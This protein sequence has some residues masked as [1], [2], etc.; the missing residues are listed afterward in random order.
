MSHL[1]RSL[2]SQ[3]VPNGDNNLSGLL[4]ASSNLLSNRS[5]SRNSDIVSLVSNGSQGPPILKE[6]H[7]A[8]LAAQ[9]PQRSSDVHDV[10]LEDV[11]TESYQSPGTSFPIQN[12]SPAYAQA[13]K[14]SAGRSKLINFDLNDVYDGSDDG[15][16]NLDR[17]PLPADRGIGPLECRSWLQQDSQQSSPPSRNSDSASTQSPSSSSSD[18]QVLIT[19]MRNM[20]LHISFCL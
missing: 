9:A 7:F 16:E 8:T 1:L 13:R 5:P 3:G 10:R 15:G 12:S 19:S 2:A 11:Q 18:A 4:Q 14:S 6:Q 17:S 20:V